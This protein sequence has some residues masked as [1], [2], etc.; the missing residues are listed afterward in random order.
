MSNK[1]TDAE[2]TNV[3][4]VL[5]TLTTLSELGLFQKMR[6]WELM[7]STLPLMYHPNS[8]IR[9]SKPTQALLV[10]AANIVRR[11]RLVHRV[12]SKG[13]PDDRCLVHLVS[14][15]EAFL[16]LGNTHRRRTINFKSA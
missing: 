1:G 14:F 2:E 4:K 10:L 3:A 12:C 15:S 13:T 9:Q 8:W 11:C 5:S 16:T 7:S 6:L